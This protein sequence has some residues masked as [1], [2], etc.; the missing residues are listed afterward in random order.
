MDDGPHQVDEDT[1]GPVRLMPIGFIHAPKHC[2]Y[3]PERRYAGRKRVIPCRGVRRIGHGLFAQA[4][5]AL[6]V[7]NRIAF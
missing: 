2:S 6:P 4:D 5:H 1:R 7:A 3:R